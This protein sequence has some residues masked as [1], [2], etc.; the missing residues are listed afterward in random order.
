[1]STIPSTSVVI[2]ED[3][4][5]LS[6]GFNLVGL[7]VSGVCPECGQPVLRSLQGNLLRYSNPEYLAGLHRGVFLVQAAIIVQVLMAIGTLV[8]AFTGGAPLVN[9]L[10]QPF[11]GVSLLASIC[12]VVGWWLLSSPDP[13]YSGSNDGTRAR[14]VV[15]IT[16]AVNAAA[17]VL[18]LV[19]GGANA[20]MVFR[21]GANN[22]AAMLSQVVGIASLIAWVVWFFA[23]MRYLQWLAPRIPSEKILKRARLMMWLG[24]VLYTVGAPFCGLGPLVALILYYNLLE[25]VRLDLRAV[26]EEIPLPPPS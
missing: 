6:C 26:R 3:R 15:R 2:S 1:M 7:S 24:P 9:S 5:C 10:V 11:Q 20:G 25:W 16:V 12:S 21:G 13:A 22:A 8:I 17:A 23:A 14:Q 4:P 18:P 19:L